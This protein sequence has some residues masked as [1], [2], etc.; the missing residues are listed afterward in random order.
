MFVL[1]SYDISDDRRRWK[2]RKTLE[3]FGTRV[4]YSVFECHLSDRQHAQLK[5]RLEKQIAA[6]LD[7]LRFYHLC[8]ADLKRVETMGLG[9][10]TTLPNCRI[11]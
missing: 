11:V 3:G 9:R 4:Q 1:V 8:A 2:V 6:R 10:V 7:S 5:R